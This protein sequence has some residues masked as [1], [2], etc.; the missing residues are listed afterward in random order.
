MVFIVKTN[1]REFEVDLIEEV[2]LTNRGRLGV[3]KAIAGKLR[4]NE[5]IL[6]IYVK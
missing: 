1:L 6:E 2:P 3:K 4:K 5:E